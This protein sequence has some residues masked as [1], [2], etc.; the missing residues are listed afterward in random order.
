M[1]LKKGPVSAALYDLD[2]DP[3]ETVILANNP[4]HAKI[5]QEMAAL[6]KARGKAVLPPGLK[7]KGN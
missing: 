2:R 5:R 4:A 6:L 7:A 1:E 3:W